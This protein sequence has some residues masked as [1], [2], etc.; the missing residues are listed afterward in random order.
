MPMFPELAAGAV[1]AVLRA[2]LHPLISVHNADRAQLS[3]LSGATV[4]RW[5]DQYEVLPKVRAVIC[6]GGA[7]TVLGALASGTPSVVIPFFADQPFNAECVAA[8]EVGLSVAPGPELD[9]RLFLSLE[10]LLNKPW[11]GCWSMAAAVRELRGIDAAVEAIESL[12]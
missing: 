10:Q 9:A 11:P 8:T 3:G 2:G 1:G 7:G 4:A 12:A 5:V 6:H